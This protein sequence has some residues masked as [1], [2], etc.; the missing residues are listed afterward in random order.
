MITGAAAV[1]PDGHGVAHDLGPDTSGVARTP[2]RRLADI[3]SDLARRNDD[4]HHG[5]IDVRILTMADGSRRVIVDITGTKSWTPFPTSDVTSL[6]T[7]GRA[8]VGESGAYEQGVLAAMRAAGV[9][10]TDPVLL[11]GHSEGGMVAVTTARDARGS[12]RY[13]VTQVITAGSP[14]GRTV[15]EIP[16]SVQVLAL[17]NE[18]DVVPHLDGVAN[19]DRPNITTAR[20]ALGNGTIADDHSLDDAYVPLAHE[21]DKTDNASLRAF[22][23]GVD[24]FLRAVSVRTTSFQVTRKYR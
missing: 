2:P 21:V 3:V 11:V 24:P 16:A 15:D 4:P 1:V 7:N 23:R 12:G 6:T 9:R 19:P 8:L 22:R 20:A 18:R 10:R 5:S 17:E 14:V 13:D